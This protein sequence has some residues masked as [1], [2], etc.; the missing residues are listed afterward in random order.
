MLFVMLGVIFVLYVG[1]MVAIG[2]SMARHHQQQLN[3]NNNNN[4]SYL[5]N[6]QKQQQQPPQQQQ[7]L[8]GNEEK[9]PADPNYFHQ[10]N[11]RDLRPPRAPRPVM[12]DPDG[13]GHLQ[14]GH[15][16]PNDWNKQEKDK[17]FGD[18]E[19]DAAID[20][21]HDSHHDPPRETNELHKE[22]QQQQQ[23]QKVVLKA[24]LEPIDRS[25]WKVKP[26]PV[27]TTTAEDLR[28][29]EYPRLNSCQNLPEQWPV[30]DYPDDDPFLPWIHDVFPTHDGRYIQFVAQN[31]RRCHTGTTAHD[32][33][34]LQHTQP[35]LSLF[36][37]V[38]I[39]RI[40]QPTEQ[41]GQEQEQRYRLSSHEDA[42]PD[43]MET[44][45]ICRF[46]PSMEE[47]LSVHNIPYEY[48]TF[49]K[50]HKQTFTERGKWDIKSLHTTQLIFQC[51]VPASLQQTVR[52][53]TSVVNDYATMFVDL[54]PI[55]TPPRYG[56]PRAFLPPRFSEFI[57]D[58]QT[59]LFRAEDEF[60]DDHVL[61]RIDDS[62]R[63]ENIPVCKPSLPTYNPPKEEPKGESSV[64]VTT[65]T[66]LAPVK[67]HRLV[68]CVWASAGYATRGERFAIH[69]GERRL[70]EWL[71]YNFLVGF[72]HVY[73]YDNSGA[74]N[75]N[76]K[77]K[78]KHDDDDEEPSLESIA[79]LFP[80][81][82]TRI[83]W[84]SKVCNNNRNF[85]DSPGERSSQYAAESS[86]RLRFGPHVDWIGAFDIDEY[87]VPVGSYN[88]I[89]PLLDKLE[90]EGK[91]IVSFGSWRAWPRKSL[92]V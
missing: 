27:R 14:V 22:P 67:K 44:R 7:R 43:G 45:F 31:K 28:L 58:N 6:Q 33:E 2:L 11:H 86:C 92:I 78:N 81:R 21:H 84:P 91:K 34:T 1:L 63:W 15:Q 53:G 30:D 49:R 23:P 36:Q 87:V 69:D 51:P 59:A 39:Q 10:Q 60:G 57:T 40:Q 3:N 64:V 18:E 19:E 73:L 62:G 20:N 16:P 9:E 37:H 55:R 29:V 82:V 66:S 47:T 80:D 26:L 17:A 61:P 12:E 35:Q 72:D 74:S 85:A 79:A 89:P 76:K 25:Q 42:D 8:R 24:Y 75:N 56:S 54:I 50:G 71:H 32:T 90:E 48:I 83:N 52:E 41:D 88:S 4:D 13:D 68:A 77:K 5:H 46:K 38:P 70:H 65:N